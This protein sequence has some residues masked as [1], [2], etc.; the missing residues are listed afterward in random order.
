MV[1]HRAFYHCSQ[2][3]LREE[4]WWVGWCTRRPGMYVH[5]LCFLRNMATSPSCFNLSPAHQ[6]AGDLH[7]EGVSFARCFLYSGPDSLRA[8]PRVSRLDPRLGGTKW[9][10]R[11]PVTTPELPSWVSRY[12]EPT[13]GPWGQSNLIWDP[14]FDRFSY[15]EKLHL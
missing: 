10:T 1:F 11:W 13:S 9:E 2:G 6:R 7:L 14:T 5:S 15:L 12:L 8:A 3:C 4:H